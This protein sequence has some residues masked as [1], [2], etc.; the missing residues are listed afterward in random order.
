[1]PGRSVGRFGLGSDR[2]KPASSVGP[3]VGPGRLKSSFGGLMKSCHL[4]AHSNSFLPLPPTVGRTAPPPPPP[5]PRKE[6]KGEPRRRPPPPGGGGSALGLGGGLRKGRRRREGTAGKNIELS[7]GR[8]ETLS[9]ATATTDSLRLLS[10]SLFLSQRLFF[11]SFPND[12][13][14]SGF[15]S[16]THTYS[17]LSAQSD[18]GP[19]SARRRLPNKRN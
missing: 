14:K 4:T 10:S 12:D 11:S 5:P 19:P 16:H 15:S 9:L 3:S 6:G 7:E 17:I 1:M 13:D 18:F 2:T 8:L